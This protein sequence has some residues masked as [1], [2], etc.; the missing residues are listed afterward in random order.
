MKPDVTLV[1][2]DLAGRLAMEIAPQ[3][4]PAYLA[5]SLALTAGVLGA[6]AEEFDRAAAWR[7]EE[8]AA[9][10]GLFSQAVG[11]GLPADLAARLQRL[12]G[13]PETNFR[14]SALDV[15]NAELRAALIE[16]HAAVEVIAEPAAAALNE[17]IWKELALS[18]ERRRL[19]SA[20]F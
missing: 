15:A 13:T 8:N 11:L 3:V 20:N 16:L 2:A 9:I 5:G 17:A 12:A 18:T 4:Q 1:L 19:G 6:T 7:I 14:V 10:R